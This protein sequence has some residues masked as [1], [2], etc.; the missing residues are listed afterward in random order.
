VP[1]LAALFLALSMLAAGA[2]QAQPFSIGQGHVPGV[3]IDNGG[4]A[5]IAWNGTESSAS[6]N[7]CRLPRGAA[8]CDRSGPI[9]TP[10]TSL[11]RP[12]VQVEGNVVRVLSYRYGFTSSPFDGVL[13]FTSIDGGATFGAG[14]LVG[15]VPFYDAVAGPGTGISLITNAVTEGMLFQHVPTDGS[16]VGTQRANFGTTHPYVGTVALI[17][18]GTPLAV[19]DSGSGMGVFR[20]YTGSGNLNDPASW[21]P[22]QDIGYTDYPHL[23]AGPSGVF[24]L[25]TD[26][27][28]QLNV[29]RYVGDS[30][31]GPASPVG[32]APGESAQDYLTQDPGGQLHVLLPQITADGSRL[33]HA[34]SNDGTSWRQTQHAFEPLAQQVR[35]A[36]AADHTGVAVWESAS[37]PPIINV[38]AISGG[39]GGPVLGRTVTA[40]VVRGTVLVATRATTRGGRAR[41]SQKGL[42]FVPLTGEREIPVGAF[43][44]TKRGTVKLESATGR[45]SRTQSGQ[46]N[47]GTFQVRQSR[48]RSAKGLTELR[49]KGGSFGRCGARGGRASAAGLSRRTI[50]RLR[51]NAKGRF[52]TGGRNSSATVRGTIW[53]TTDRCDGTLTAVKRGRVA[54]RDFHRKRTVVVSA[55]K[56]YLARVR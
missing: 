45:G 44:N 22:A 13:L 49:L 27:N 8:A 37:N 11:S 21:T 12:F 17:D 32:A 26:V 29:R 41:A 43:L 36:V 31:F 28:R 52:R 6:L 9:A 1:P 35:A 23:A 48:K 18:P 19:F 4:T 3:A 25:A 5:Y 38:M 34:T 30:G 55:G 7:F 2:A 46:F 14:V 10:G 47:G 54:V 16:S 51:A 50:R 42:N 53:T 39:A 56:S 40:S 15:S 24:M 33:M 20:R